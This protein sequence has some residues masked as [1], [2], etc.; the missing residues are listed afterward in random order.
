MGHGT[1]RNKERY[2]CIV[3]VSATKKSGI[4]PT[5]SLVEQAFA[6]FGSMLVLRLSLALII[7]TI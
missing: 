5:E 3:D 7:L 6:R 1:Q 2:Q 4:V